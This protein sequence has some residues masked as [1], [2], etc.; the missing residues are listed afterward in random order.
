MSL[1]P[2]TLLLTKFEWKTNRNKKKIMIIS[3]NFKCLEENRLQSSLLHRLFLF[4]IESIDLSGFFVSLLCVHV[5]AFI[6]VCVC[7]YVFKNKILFSS[8]GRVVVRWVVGGRY[9]HVL[10]E[11]VQIANIFSSLAFLCSS[12]T[13]T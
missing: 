9:E 7:M 12:G 3:P 10:F 5:C 11:K 1:T 4:N 6:Y 13:W 2:E 8:M